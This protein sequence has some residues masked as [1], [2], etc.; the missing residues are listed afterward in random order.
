MDLEFKDSVSNKKS[1]RLV[2]AVKGGTVS[3]QTNKQAQATD[4][5]CQGHCWEALSPESLIDAAVL[6]ESLVTGRKYPDK[7]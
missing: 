7:K 3:K 6:V 2:W 1:G 4:F 5:L